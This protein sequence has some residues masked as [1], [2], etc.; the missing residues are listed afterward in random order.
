MAPQGVRIVVYT[1]GWCPHCK[2]AKAW[3]AENGIPYEERNIESSSRNAEENR[4]LNPRGS[5]PTFDV[6]GEVL[7]GFSE[8][9]LVAM[10]E[11]AAQRQGAPAP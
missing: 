2:R 11:R 10:I 1:T 5:I 6:D 8:A 3:M 7:I 4:K 9:D